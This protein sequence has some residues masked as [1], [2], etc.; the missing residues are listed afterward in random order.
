MNLKELIKAAVPRI[1]DAV[2]ER[3]APIL[4]ELM[5]K[6]EIDTPLRRNHFLAQLPH[7]SGGFRYVREIA[8]GSAYEGRRDLGN[9]VP[10]DG[11][12]FKGRGLIQIT[13]RANYTACS[14]ALFGDNRLLDTPELLE[15]P[16]YAVESACW[17]WKKS[18]LNALADR[19]DIVAV[20]RRING[21]INGLEDRRRYYN[22]LSLC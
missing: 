17:F 7:E 14:Q 3:Y 5:S 10:G 16:Y 9:T 21:G 19:D 2:N 22:K 8:S 4:A 11:V 15:E 13:G 1:D 12:K 20:T 18:N 6:Y